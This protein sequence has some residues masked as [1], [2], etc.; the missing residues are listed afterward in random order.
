MQSVFDCGVQ[1]V[2]E[3]LDG[4]Q[5]TSVE[6]AVLKKI[7][8]MVEVTKLLVVEVTWVAGGSLRFVRNIVL[9]IE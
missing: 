2:L 7:C 6:K 9:Q 3:Q 8:E 4:R 1:Y 5:L